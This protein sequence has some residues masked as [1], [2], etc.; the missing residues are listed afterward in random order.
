MESLLLFLIYLQRC[1]EVVKNFR[2]LRYGLWCLP[3][4]LFSVNA[5]LKD[6]SQCLLKEYRLDLYL[7]GIGYADFLRA[8]L[9]EVS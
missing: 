2:W 5:L 6:A 9:I 8:L 3:T 4:S 7:N 1:R